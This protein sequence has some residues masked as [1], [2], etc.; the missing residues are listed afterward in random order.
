MDQDSLGTLFQQHRQ[1]VVRFVHRQYNHFDEETL[2]QL[3]SDLWSSVASAPNIRSMT[4]K[5]F[6]ITALKNRVKNY[7][8]DMSR[9]E[10][11]LSRFPVL[12]LSDPEVVEAADTYSFAAKTYVVDA[13]D[14]EASERYEAVMSGLPPTLRLVAELYYIDDCTQEEI[15]CHFQTNRAKVLRLLAKATQLIKQRYTYY[16]NAM[17]KRELSTH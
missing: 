2:D 12:S 1:Q 15:A 16:R 14:D 3:Y 8:R 9:S 13:Q 6:L 17:A 7:I 10:D 4:I 5:S 11:V